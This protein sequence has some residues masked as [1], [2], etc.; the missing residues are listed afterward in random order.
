[1]AARVREMTSGKPA[2]LILF[3]ALPLMLGN[4]FQQMYTMVD[5]IIVGQFVG[6][7]ALAALGVCEWINWLVQGT[8]SGFTQGFSILISHR[9]GAEDWKGLRKSVATSAILGAVIAL[10][11]TVI[12]VLGS[13]PLLYLLNTPEDVIDIALDYMY[14]LYGGTAA[15]TAY[16]TCAAALRAMGDSKTP[17]IAMIIASLTNIVLDLVFVLVFHWGV[18]G[19]AAATVIAQVCSFLVCLNA[20]R[21]IPVLQMEKEDWKPEARLSRDMFVVGIPICFQN[22]II[23][24]G[25]LVV[26]YVVNGFG[27]LFVAGFTATN[28]LY[29]LLEVAATSFGF[30]MATYCGQNLGAKK[31]KRIKSG[32]RVAAVMA[33]ITALGI[34]GFM[35]LFGKQILMLFISGDPA[36]A[37]QVL[38]IA[39]TYLMYMCSA[40]FI[41]Y[42]LYVYRSALQGLGDT[43]T[44]MVSGIAE[45]I[46][47]IG[48]ALLLP[49]FIGQQ[50]IYY[51]EILAWLGAEVILMTVYYIRQNH[52]LKRTDGID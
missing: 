41:L 19:A 34:A 13:R 5:L 17:L 12:S 26:Q 39:F 22:I 44:P 1:M 10:V 47:R 43:I 35:V 42:L 48:A 38:D 4:V 18:G 21:R 28:K 37:Q 20:L 24:I 9:F 3:F 23:S 25:G 52:L 14:V 45:L 15:Y 2:G 30:S 50:G 31:Y 49:L 6:V 29:G 46:M 33:V 27:L 8:V 16:N 51:A 32:T 7:T 11:V 36:E 40:L